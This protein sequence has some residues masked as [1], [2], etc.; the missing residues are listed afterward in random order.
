[1][2][3]IFSRQVAD[4]LREKYTV[5]ELETV[6]VPEKQAVMETFCVVPAEKIAFEMSGLDQNITLHNQFVQ[7][8]KDNNPQLCMGLYE[9]LLGK[10]GGELDSFYD[11]IK[12]RCES[13]NSTVV[14]IP[15]HYKPVG[16]AE[17][18]KHKPK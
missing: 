18:L 16:P 14:P 17:P 13:T 7:A 5:L 4:Q 11:V 2:Q 9:H 8:I 3:I 15:D 12:Q 1:M 10:F 6:P